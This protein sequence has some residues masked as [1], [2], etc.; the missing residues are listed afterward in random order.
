MRNKYWE[1]LSTACHG[2]NTAKSLPPSVS[3][4]RYLSGLLNGRRAVLDTAQ[5]LP[6]RAL[7]AVTCAA[8][9]RRAR[10]QDHCLAWRRSTARSESRRPPGGLPGAH[11]YECWNAIQLPTCL[12]A[13]TRQQMSDT[14]R[15]ARRGDACAG[16]SIGAVAYKCISGDAGGNQ[17]RGMARGGGACSSWRSS[18]A[19]RL[20]GI[21]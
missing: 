14:A 8:S 12:D 9:R 13:F 1:G 19:V 2:Q 10:P 11:R 18:V 16:A 3:M 6:R 7:R 5:T 17:G 15:A 21:C 4:R 20:S